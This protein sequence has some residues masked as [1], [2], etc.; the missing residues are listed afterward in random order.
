MPLSE[1]NAPAAKRVSR[2][3][4]EH[5][6]LRALVLAGCVA[7]VAI[8]AMEAWRG[9]LAAFDR[10]AYPALL[11]ALATCAAVLTWAP[12][13]ADVARVI[14]VASF[15]AYP[16][17]AL[18]QVLFNG[19]G[20]PDE[21]QLLTNLYWLPMAYGTA[22]IFLT[23]RAA[24]ILSATVYA[25]TFGLILWHLHR[26]DMA[27]W[28]AYLTPMMSNLSVAQ[29]VYIIVLL[30]VSRLRAD[31]YRS[32]AKMEA[33]RQVAA[34]DP[35]TRLLNRRAL[36]ERLIA[37][38]SLVQRGTQPMSVIL[39]D[40]DHFKQIND[41]GGHLLGDQVLVDLAERLQRELRAADSLGRWGGEEFLVLAPATRL[42]AAAELAER[43]RRAAAE[44]P[45]VLQRN[46][47]LSL[48]V[49]ECRHGEPLDDLIARADR[50]LYAAKLAGRNR[51]CVEG[52]FSPSASLA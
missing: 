8:W 1:F 50:A 28:P 24:V 11:A 13:H 9:E 29:I 37:N 32:E 20:V 43:I 5:S 21:Y 3:S 45:N 48:G 49:A 52:E 35:L 30:S 15:N 22:F 19:D 7:L 31:Y 42:D 10:W 18:F 41:Q 25:A 4:R 46:I 34:T 51:V 39:I 44:T 14:A 27:H 38:Q 6:M 17:L 26:G 23:M 33:I 16:P 36:T 47:T 40:V 2:L 12:A